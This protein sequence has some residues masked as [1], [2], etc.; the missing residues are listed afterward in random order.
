[1]CKLICEVVGRRIQ[2]PRVL[3]GFRFRLA[4][5]LAQ[6]ADEA[7]RDDPVYAEFVLAGWRADRERAESERLRAE[8]ERFRAL[9]A[10]REAEPDRHRAEE[11]AGRLRALGLDPEEQAPP[12]S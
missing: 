2:L 3:P 9:A 10:E 7:L 12:D 8:A 11:L 6:P 5:L 1:M 4:D